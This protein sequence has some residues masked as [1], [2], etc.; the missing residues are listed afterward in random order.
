MIYIK[1]WLEHYSELFPVEE[2]QES[3]LLSLVNQTNCPAKLLSVECGASPFTEQ[4]SNKFDLTVTDSF[5]EFISS[6]TKRNSAEQNSIHAFNLL[7]NDI[8][9]YLGKN[10]FDVICFPNYRIIFLKEKAQ[11]EKFMLDAKLLLKDGGYLVIDLINFTKFDFSNTRIE[12]PTRRSERAELVST[13]I[14][15]SEN[16]KYKLF[17]Q[18]VTSSGKVIDEVKD[19]E[20]CPISLETFKVFAKNL[21]FSSIDFYNDY[22]KTPYTLDSDK[23]ICVLKK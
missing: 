22:N 18:L 13:I 21:G 10:F 4:F 5:P 12:L 7:P 15:D 11:I 20:I 23:I 9:R 8:G 17:Q 16:A 14:K 19:E 6:I 2:N 1:R 3:F